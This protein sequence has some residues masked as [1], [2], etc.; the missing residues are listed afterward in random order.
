LTNKM[1]MLVNSHCGPHKVPRSAVI[2]QLWETA[3][4]Y[5][6]TVVGLHSC[7]EFPFT[8]EPVRDIL[9]YQGWSPYYHEGEVAAK[10]YVPANQV[11]RVERWSPSNPQGPLDVWLNPKYASPSPLL[12]ERKLIP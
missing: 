6:W 9:I 11:Q 12:N 3:L 10:I 5:C 8:S 2:R 4:F 7:V 1:Q